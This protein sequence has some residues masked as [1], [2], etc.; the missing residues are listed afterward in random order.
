MAG[1]RRDQNAHA[2]LSTHGTDDYKK[3]GKPAV[4]IRH[5]L[6][7]SEESSSS[8]PPTPCTATRS[9]FCWPSPAPS[10]STAWPSSPAR[11]SSQVS[12]G[13]GQV[14]PNVFHNMHL[15]KF[16]P[17]Q[18]FLITSSTSTITTFTS[19]STS[20]SATT[21]LEALCSLTNAP[22]SECPPPSP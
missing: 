2:A 3:R 10:P 19:T 7:N 4:F 18:R 5:S 11:S 6:T 15:M 8:S 1:R 16:Q 21:T 13:L 20:Y 12:R 22:F 9:S 14:A 17:G